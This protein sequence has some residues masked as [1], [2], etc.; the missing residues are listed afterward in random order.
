MCRPVINESIRDGVFPNTLKIA[1]V[2][3]LFK[4]GDSEIPTNYRQISVLTYFSK[5]FEKVLYGRLNDYQKKQLVESAT[6]RFSKQLFH[7]PGYYRLVRKT[8]S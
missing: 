1:K 2:I 4:S 5:I 8:S 3:P 6:I 7:I